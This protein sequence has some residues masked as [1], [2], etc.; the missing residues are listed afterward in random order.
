MY[1]DNNMCCEECVSVLFCL[2]NS[3]TLGFLVIIGGLSF[4]ADGESG[5]FLVLSIPCTEYILNV[6]KSILFVI[7]EVRLLYIL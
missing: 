5:T 7:L 3:T 1:D 4:L 2:I 6:F